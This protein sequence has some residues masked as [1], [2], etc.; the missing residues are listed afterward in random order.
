VSFDIDRL[1]EIRSG[2]EQ[3]E[4]PLW[5]RDFSE[6]LHFVLSQSFNVNNCI[7]DQ[8]KQDKYLSAVR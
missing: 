7:F 4:Y 3:G 5:S 2:L 1:E 8:Y 6:S